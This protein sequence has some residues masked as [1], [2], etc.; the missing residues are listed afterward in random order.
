[1]TSPSKSLAKRVLSSDDPRNEYVELR[2]KCSGFYL[3]LE[4]NLFDLRSS[5]P[6]E[7]E[8]MLKT[9]LDTLTCLSDWMEAS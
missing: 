8:A 3:P 6:L 5:D 2:Q 9:A 7:S 1:M 4:I